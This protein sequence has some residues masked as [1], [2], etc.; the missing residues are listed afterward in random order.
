MGIAGVEPRQLAPTVGRMG[1]GSTDSLAPS[2]II[3]NLTASTRFDGSSSVMAVDSASPFDIDINPLTINFDTN[4]KI[5][6]DTTSTINVGIAVSAVID[7]IPSETEVDIARSTVIDTAPPSVANLTPAAIIIDP[8]SS[9]AGAVSAV[10]GG[11][12]MA[13]GLFNFHVDNDGV[14]E[15]ISVSD[16]TPPAA[17]P[18]ASPAIE[19]NLSTT[20]SLTPSEEEP[21]LETLTPSVGS[22]DFQDPPLSPTTA[23]CVE[24]DAYHFVGAGDF[25]AHE[26]A[27]CEDPRGGTAAIYP[28]ISECERVLNTLTLRPTLSSAYFL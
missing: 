16:L 3:D 24:C 19:G 14:A 13:F 2:P 21:S 18:S 5:D 4:D 1:S 17:A 23:Y 8:T 20:M 25:S 10:T 22:N 28:T 9:T 27:G 15:L 12:D 6:I 7:T 11:F 26:I